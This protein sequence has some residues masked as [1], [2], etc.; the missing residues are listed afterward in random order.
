M[1]S[2]G[3]CL[4][5]WHFVILVKSHM[6]YTDCLFLTAI[7]LTETGIYLYSVVACQ[8]I[9]DNFVITVNISKA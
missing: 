1:K 3:V 7:L 2:N 6:V 8:Y 4:H 9:L 5:T